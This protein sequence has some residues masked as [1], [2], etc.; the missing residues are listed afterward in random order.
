MLRDITIENYRLFEKFHIEGLT[1]VNL[2]VGTNNSGKS[3]LL[4]AI[5]LLVSQE[6]PVALFRIL[7]IRG[8]ITPDNYRF[9]SRGGYQV[10]HIFRN[11]SLREGSIKIYSQLSLDTSISLT[12][13]YQEQL[14]RQLSLFDENK[15]VSGLEFSYGDG[16]NRLFPMIEDGLIEADP[17]LPRRFVSGE[18]NR[19]VTT[20]YL[21]QR[22]VARLWDQITL[23]PEEDKVLEALRIL[24]PDIERIGFTSQQST[25]S[26]ILLKIKG[27]DYPI[28]LGS[29]GDGMRRILVLAASMANCE[30]GVLLVDEIDT[31]LHYKA[32]TQMWRLVIETANRL[33]VQV[34]ATT[35]SWDCLAAFHKALTETSA[36]ELGSVFRLE[37]KDDQIK[38]VSYT[39]DKLAVAIDHDIEVR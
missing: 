15:Y 23:T 16:N 36:T 1:Q 2:L 5:Y 10:S 17:R 14:P 4:E 35:H 26:G 34:F 39:G 27:N 13:S 30:N 38:Y 20:D 18:N 8:E 9:K 37:R 32:L 7:D 11:H 28:P 6:V 29:M 31:G 12:V 33:N 22:E 19:F 24:E 21:D 3:S 25:K